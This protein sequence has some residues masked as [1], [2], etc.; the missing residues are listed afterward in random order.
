MGSFS[1]FTEK[2]GGVLMVAGV[3]G[4]LENK[5]QFADAADP[6]TV[7]WR[8]FCQA[9]WAEYQ[10]KE[11]TSGD[12]YDVCFFIGA[13]AASVDYKTKRKSILMERLVGSDRVNEQG[14][15]CK[16]GR[17][18]AKRCG[19]VFLISGESLDGERTEDF[20]VKIVRSERNTACTLYFLSPMFDEQLELGLSE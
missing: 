20:S 9:W 12:L 19:Q 6:I 10:K 7:E 11:V 1:D 5:K 2:L 14:A 16:L 3:E 18:L 4:F 13:S 8:Q 17:H 15:K